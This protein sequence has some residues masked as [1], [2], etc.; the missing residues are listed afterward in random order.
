MRQLNKSWD[1]II[2]EE[3]ELIK[4]LVSPE[5]LSKLSFLIVVQKYH[6]VDFIHFH[7]PNWSMQ[8]HL[9][10]TDLTS[11]IQNGLACSTSSRQTIVIIKIS[12]RR[13]RS[14]IDRIGKYASWYFG[15]SF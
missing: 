1:Y 13:N 9:A 10:T 15:N 2:Q 12:S 4:L 11:H 5:E 14:E 3:S 8:L 7:S 6:F